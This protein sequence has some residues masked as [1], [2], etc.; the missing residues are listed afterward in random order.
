VAKNATDV[1]QIVSIA[2]A[3]EEYARKH[4]DRS[5]ELDAIELRFHSECRLD[6]MISDPL[7]RSARLP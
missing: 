3:M 5:L 2:A 1:L 7:E 6:D 4:N